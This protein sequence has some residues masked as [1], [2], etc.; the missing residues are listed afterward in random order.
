MGNGENAGSSRPPALAE[1]LKRYGEGVKWVVSLATG[2]L[3]LGGFLVNAGLPLAQRILFSLTALS[4][5]AAIMAGV[6]CAL[7]V[8][9]FASHAE[10]ALRAR[11]DRLQ[12]EREEAPDRVADAERRE[13]AALNNRD[14]G[15]R[16]SQRYWPVTLWAYVLGMFFFVLFAGAR[17][18]GIGDPKADDPVIL[19]LVSA[20]TDPSGL[21]LLQDTRSGRLYRLAQ[22]DSLGI[23][24]VH[25]PFRPAEEDTAP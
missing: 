8:V 17:V 9:A 5:I 7:N 1:G 15:R 22:D 2:S 21:V 25:L 20:G 13:R 24:F 6:L 12:A 3:T 10:A 14:H 4:L 19:N 11:E 23:R 16:G 18:W